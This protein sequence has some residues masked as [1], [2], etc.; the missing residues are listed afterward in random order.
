[1]LPI[2]FFELCISTEYLKMITWYTNINYKLI[3]D[4][5][6]NDTL[7][8]DF[9][10]EMFSYLY[11][12]KKTTKVKIEIFLGILLMQSTCKLFKSQKLLKYA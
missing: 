12:W 2:Q 8:S 7:N 10:H 4:K 1:M 3:C 5:T 11:P 9:K 6:S